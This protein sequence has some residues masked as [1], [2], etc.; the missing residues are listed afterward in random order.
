MKKAFDKLSL[1]LIKVSS[2]ILVLVAA[3]MVLNIILRSLLKAP[4]AGTMEIVELGMLICIVMVLSRTGF[5]ERHIAVTVLV[6][7]L[8]PKAK[9]VLKFI[10]M[11]ISSVVF[12][13]LIFSFIGAVPESIASGALT[14]IYRLP[15]Y[16]VYII[17]S[18]GMISATI[19]FLYHAFAALAPFFKRNDD[20]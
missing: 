6:D 20:A 17:L 1:V 11:I 8:P 9:A 4:I 7:L 16:W 10:S 15:Y 18:L 12:G 5:T 19:M 13:F 2:V 14:D 3:T